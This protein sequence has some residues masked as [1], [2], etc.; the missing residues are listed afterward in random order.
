[1]SGTITVNTGGTITL[2]SAAATANQTVCQNVAITN[3]TYGV[4]GDATG[5]NVTGLPTGVT[6]NFSGGVLTISGTPTAS[7]TFNYTVT[8][9]GSACNNPSLNGTITVNPAPTITATP[10]PIITCSGSQ[11]TIN[12]SSSIN[13]PAPGT[14]YN[15][16]RTNTTNLVG[17]DPT[18]PGGTFMPAT[19]VGA[20]TNLLTTQQTSVFT[21]IATGPN[22]CAAA[23]V[24]VTV[25]VNPSP[26]VS[27]AANS[28]NVCSGSTL[29]L[30]GSPAGGTW[31]S[32]NPG[33]ATV[34][35]S[36]LVTGVATSGSAIITY[37]Y[38][39]QQRFVW[40]QLL[41]Q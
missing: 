35:G 31:S 21:F 3:I 10:T 6:P 14:A 37:S 12:L 33:V 29:T 19:L 9:T 26:T 32:N 18:G 27:I 24:Q 4:G 8:T 38:T 16:I 36:G 15:W 23:P 20:L 40:V 7:G 41:N 39:D 25:N 13:T 17:M 30:S 11:F 28:G 2:T 34:N 1:L 22:G 5:A